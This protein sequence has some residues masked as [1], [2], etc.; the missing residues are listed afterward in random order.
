MQYGRR[1]RAGFC[2]ALTRARM[3]SQEEPNAILRFS[4]ATPTSRNPSSISCNDARS[5][6]GNCSSGRTRPAEADQV[7]SRA[8]PHI[9]AHDCMPRAVTAASTK[10]DTLRARLAACSTPRRGSARSSSNGFQRRRHVAASLPL[11]RLAD[12]LP[13][14]RKPLDCEQSQNAKWM[15]EG[16]TQRVAE[17]MK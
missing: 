8:Q 3:A 1:W 7:R 9:Q 16:M 14:E 5:L 6:R 10:A 4:R 2:F 17:S 12:E 15:K 13:N 11:C